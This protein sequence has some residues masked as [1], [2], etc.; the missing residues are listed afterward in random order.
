MAPAEQRL[1]PTE[2]VELRTDYNRQMVRK[3]PGKLFVPLKL[4]CDAF[5][6]MKAPWSERQKARRAEKRF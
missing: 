4:P 5:H 1:S 6:G 3:C 2:Y